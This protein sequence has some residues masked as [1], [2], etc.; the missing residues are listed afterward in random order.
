MFKLSAE[1]IEIQKEAVAMIESFAKFYG[2]REVGA[3]E[4]EI[5][6]HIVL[7]SYKNKKG[8]ATVLGKLGA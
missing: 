2:E 3:H 8:Y 5:K 7:V 4:V 6:D 1:V